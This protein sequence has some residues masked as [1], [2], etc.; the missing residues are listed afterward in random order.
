MCE[1]FD[2][3]CFLT[4]EST[5]LAPAL[6]L[7]DGSRTPPVP[8]QAAPPR[9]TRS[10][11][12]NSRLAGAIQSSDISAKMATSASEVQLWHFISFHSSRFQSMLQSKGHLASL[13]FH[14]CMKA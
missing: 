6:L 8:P 1:E 12:Q 4:L 10:H 2:I 11:L 7:Q 13:V 3:L 5:Q 14:Q 9:S